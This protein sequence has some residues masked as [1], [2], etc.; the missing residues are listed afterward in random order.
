MPVPPP[1]QCCV[2]AAVSCSCD[3]FISLCATI[4][5]SLN[6]Q[7]NTSAAAAI[8]FRAKGLPCGLARLRAPAFPSCS[9]AVLLGLATGHSVQVL[10]VAAAGGLEVVGAVVA[11]HALVGGGGGALPAGAVVVLQR[12]SRANSWQ[13]SV[14]SFC[15]LHQAARSGL[16]CGLSCSGITGSPPSHPCGSAHP[17]RR[18]PWPSPGEACVDGAEG[19]GHCE[20]QAC[21]PA[22]VCVVGG[23]AAFSATAPSNQSLLADTASTHGPLNRPN[24]HSLTL[25]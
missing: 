13:P 9:L 2:Q 15:Q 5:S 20:L 24:Q 4:Y 12:T 16:G 6:M 21:E 11:V 19:S 22:T 1:R 25:M 14:G 23:M 10:A 8:A 17:R 7:L 18:A 3:P